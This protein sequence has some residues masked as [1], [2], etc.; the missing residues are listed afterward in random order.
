MGTRRSARSAVVNSNGKREGSSDSGIWRG[1]R[2]S[3]R[4]SGPDAWH[5]SEPSRKR[6]RTEESTESVHSNDA[7]AADKI[8][9]SNGV[10]VKA[11]GAAALKPTEI[12][13]EQ[14]AGKKRS[15][16]WVYAVE[17]IPDAQPSLAVPPSNPSTQNGDYQ[18]EHDPEVNGNYT[19]GTPRSADTNGQPNT[20][21][22]ERSP[23]RSF[24]PMQA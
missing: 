19:N 5:D 14:I 8:V 6:A 15:K 17:P 16:F 13:L 24:S 21:D 10:R 9:V 12:A 11:S 4:L 18:H 23:G 20:R 3:S 1:E 22:R 7:S 2:R